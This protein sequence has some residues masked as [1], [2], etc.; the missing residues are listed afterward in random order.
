MCGAI[1]PRHIL[2]FLHNFH[3]ATNEETVDRALLRSAIH[4]WRKLRL[5]YRAGDGEETRRIV[6]SIILGYADTYRMLIAWYDL[7]DGFRHFRTGRI[8]EVETLNDP[9]GEA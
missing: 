8:I 4:G 2:G 1:A 6:W 5:P 9:I 3:Q 7:R